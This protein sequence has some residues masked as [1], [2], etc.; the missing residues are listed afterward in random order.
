[1]VFGRLLRMYSKS[2][3]RRPVLTLCCVN[4]ML[5]I[6]GDGLAQGM[7]RYDAWASRQQQTAHLLEEHLPPKLQQHPTNH[8]NDGQQ[9][10]LRYDW[11]R[12]MRF[13]AYN[14][15]V[16][17]I[18]GGWYIL[19]DR[20]FPNPA[21]AT[22]AKPRR[23][24]WIPVKRMGLDQLLFAPAGLVLFFTVM[25]FAE[26]RTWHGIKEKFQDAYLPAL[27]ANYKVWPL[28]QLINFTFVP[29]PFRLPFVNSIGILWNGYLSWLNNASKRYEE[30]HYT[31]THSSL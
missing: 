24:N 27:T 13:A 7:L 29:L 3:E 20:L 1:M 4:A 17:P 16:A 28:V 26:T 8:Q 31:L 19:L 9:P 15:S 2:Y 14:F 30:E 25:G 10:G 22:S 18:A 23:I 21:A 5:G 11:V 6:M 12:T